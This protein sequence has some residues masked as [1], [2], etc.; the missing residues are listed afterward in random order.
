MDIAVTGS[1]GLI[2]TAF[3]AAA[4][5]RGDRVVRVVRRR[6]DSNEIGWDIDAGTIDA[7]R[8]NGIDAVV[9]LAGEA[10]ANKKWTPQQ[11]QIIEDSRIKAT[12][13]LSTA[14][15][16]L[17]RP[18]PVLLNGSAIGI[19]GDRG[20]EQ[21]TESSGDGTGYL[22]EL[23][24]DWEATTAPAED[25]G[26][27]VVQLR[28]GLVLSAEGGALGEQLPFFKLGLGG[29]IGSGQQYWSWISIDDQ[30]GGML[31][32]LDHDLS[33]PVNLTGPTPERNSDYISAVGRA[34]R[35]PTFIPTPKIALDLRLGKEAV[36]EM[37]FRSQRVLPAA[38]LASGYEFVHPTLDEALADLI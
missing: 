6:P 36:R 25:A 12:G 35:R 2:G 21:L 28:T 31:H 19:Y 10:L 14:L 8:F 32:L 37:L 34:V 22:A 1:T 30:V 17:D 4:E 29:R 38:L 13:L 15:A 23:C 5:R 11:K 16:G 24:I 3:V 7:A 26:V 9:H 18:P 27:R 20:D 33:G